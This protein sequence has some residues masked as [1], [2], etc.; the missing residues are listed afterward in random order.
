MAE[1]RDSDTFIK[2]ELALLG[3]EIKKYEFWS[4]YWISN[5]RAGLRQLIGTAP[6]ASNQET[7]V[8]ERWMGWDRGVIQGI[9]NFAHFTDFLI[10]DHDIFIEFGPS[11]RILRKICH[12]L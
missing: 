2:L 5:L 6:C 11:T 7:C 1:V 9:M 12:K 8:V 3:I 10:P 4:A